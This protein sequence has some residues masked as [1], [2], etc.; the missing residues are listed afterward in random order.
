MYSRRVKR[1][2][3]VKLSPMVVAKQWTG[4]KG[5]KEEKRR[6]G[7]ERI[8][9]ASVACCEAVRGSPARC[10]LAWCDAIW[11]GVAWR[12][13]AWHARVLPP[14][15]RWHPYLA[16]TVCSIRF[17]FTTLLGHKI[18]GALLKTIQTRSGSFGTPFGN[19]AYFAT[20]IASV[21]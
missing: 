12:G 13:V 2:K 7:E 15:T 21:I 4:T 19:V 20:R 9:C 16:R 5:R 3:V 11:H 6:K 14:V 8:R 17:E 18:Y 1:C 10:L